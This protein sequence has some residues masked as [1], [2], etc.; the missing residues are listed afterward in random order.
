ME[1]GMLVLLDGGHSAGTALDL[2]DEWFDPA[3][4]RRPLR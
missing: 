3:L 1:R 4:R 2:P